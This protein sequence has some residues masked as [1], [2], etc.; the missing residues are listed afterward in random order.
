MFVDDEA[1]PALTAVTNEAPEDTENDSDSDL[2]SLEPKQL[3]TIIKELRAELSRK[4]F[5]LNFFESAAQNL[6]EKRDAVVSI[7]D[8]IDN[9]ASIKSSLGALEVRSIAASARPTKIDE[10]WHEHLSQHQKAREWWSSKKPKPLQGVA[11]ISD[12]KKTNVANNI[13][14]RNTISSNNTHTTTTNNSQRRV[15]APQRPPTHRGSV[16][17]SSSEPQ[18]RERRQ[19]LSGNRC[20]IGQVQARS[21]TGQRAKERC[22]LCKRTGHSDVNCFRNLTCSYCQRRGHLEQDCRTRKEHE[23]QELLFTKLAT[24]QANNNALL[25]QSLNKF[26]TPQQS[27]GVSHATNWPSLASNTRPY[28]WPY[29]QQYAR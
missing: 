20:N 19:Q 17:P 15:Q 7:L 29:A 24:D 23:R 5:V 22:Q 16:P 10:E 9:T 8:L 12:K 18:T 2:L 26:L 6:A 27:S 13:S 3:I 25:I 14:N 28:T 1:E 11:A 21:V 4:K